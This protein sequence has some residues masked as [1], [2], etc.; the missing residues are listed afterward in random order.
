MHLRG[1]GSTFA[2]EIHQN[3]LDTEQPYRLAT[4]INY[5]AYDAVGSIP[6]MKETHT[7]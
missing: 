1:A 6:E 4:L 5:N 7:R 3:W 2:A